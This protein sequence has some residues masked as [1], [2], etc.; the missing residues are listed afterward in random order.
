MTTR[1]Q[2]RCRRTASC[3]S[4]RG[5]GRKVESPFPSLLTTSSV[6]R[7]KR[8]ARGSHTRAHIESCSP[9]DIVFP[10]P[11]PPEALADGSEDSEAASVCSREEAIRSTRQR[12][13]NQQINGSK[14]LI[15]RL[16][17]SAS[18]GIDGSTERERENSQDREQRVRR[19]V[20]RQPERQRDRG[21]GKA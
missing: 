17:G 18:E 5:K 21:R 12:V 2:V 15:N 11:T 4:L 3:S 1:D 7:P 6:S 16:H 19:C 13:T 9:F 10:S 14:R 20:A 8:G